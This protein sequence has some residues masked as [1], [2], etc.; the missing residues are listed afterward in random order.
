[1]S[2]AGGIISNQAVTTLEE[3]AV[4]VTDGRERLNIEFA[5]GAAALTAFEVAYLTVDSSSA[6]YQVV[7]NAGADF[8]APGVN[9][10]VR[11]ADSDLTTAAVGEHFLV[12]DTMGIA[13][14]RIRASSGTSSTV[15][16]TWGS[17]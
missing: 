13:K 12:L 15:T 10:A 2:Q 6:T 8:T 9:D 3:V 1:M 14:V 4:I 17:A 16:G 5:V 7:A 11:G